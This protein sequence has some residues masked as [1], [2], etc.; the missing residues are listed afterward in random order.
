MTQTPKS[1]KMHTWK[2][3]LL[4]CLIHSI[5]IPPTNS[6]CYWSLIHSP[7]DF[8]Q[9]YWPTVCLFVF[10]VGIKMFILETTMRI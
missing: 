4:L 3:P 5:S 7:R 6:Y 2:I 9:T 10:R 1:A 8:Y